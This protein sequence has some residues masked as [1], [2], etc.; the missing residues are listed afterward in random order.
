MYR[1][2]CIAE[3]LVDGPDDEARVPHVRPLHQG[4]AEKQEDDG[5]AGGT[6]IKHSGTATSPCYSYRA[7]LQK[8]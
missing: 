5:V 3:E 7:Q 1:S 6:A 8:L 2:G 4:D